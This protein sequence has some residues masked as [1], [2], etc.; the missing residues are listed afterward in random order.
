MKI[1]SKPLFSS[2]FVGLALSLV[3]FQIFAEEP[4]EEAWNLYGQFTYIWHQKDRFA[5][6]YTNLNGSPNSLVPNKERSYTTTLTAF[7]GLR[8]WK[9]GEL[10]AAPEII[11]ELPLSGLR[12]LGGSIQNGELEKNGTR[13]PTLYRSR[14]FLR[15]T[16]DL[17]G[18]SSRVESGP[19]QLAGTQ[20]SRRFVLTAGNLSIIDLFD[21]NSYVGDVR[22]QFLNMNFLTYSAFD[23]AADARGYSW[24][25]SGE[26]YRDEW[27]FRAGRFIGP[28]HPNQLQLNYKIMRFYGDQMEL[29]H[30][31]DLY[32]RPGKVRLLGY[33]NAE[34]MGRW[35]DAM[36][37][38][39]ADP[40][41]NAA[42]CTDFN[43]GSGNAGAPDLCWVRKRN[44]KI[45][46][47]M[48][49]E[50]SIAPDIGVFFRGMK[51]DGK[52]EVF[53]YT[54]TDSSISF[55][56]S[57]KGTR[58]GRERDAVGVGYARNW[59]SSLHVAYLNLGGID[60]FIGDGRI[61]YKPEKAVEAYYNFN[62]NS[63]LWLTLD[64]Q[65]VSN[66][67]YNADRGPVSLY[68]I[69]VHAEF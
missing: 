54:A 69:R 52:T 18:D 3:T 36:N 57:I 50:Q 51:S 28:I 55:G 27:A 34:N 37:S 39:I 23:F 61:A 20:D 9:G 35:D 67:A 49:L 48:N 66:P 5:A 24:G 32:G 8:L 30:K 68:G 53:A 22:Q 45:G 17:G 46:V 11:S 6:R 38:I 10:Y 41:K 31:H 64:A 15:Q 43:Y 7:A 62:V 16:W 59:L 21:K 13:K 2:L 58:W 12:G 47:G 33:R 29:E 40:N 44:A 1:A 56:A 14:L 63:F 26:Y 42:A 25:I 60:G 19:M 4:A 65:R